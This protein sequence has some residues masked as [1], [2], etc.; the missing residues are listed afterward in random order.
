MLGP[1][2]GAETS[3]PASDTP[4]P[5]SDLAAIFANTVN[6]HKAA[7]F[8][9]IYESTF[10]P[11][12]DR[13]M[14]IL[15]IGVACGGSLELWRQY[16]CPE[17]TVIGIDGNPQCARFDDPARNVHVRIGQQQ[18][19]QFLQSVV[20]EF[21][22][23]DIILDDGAHTP[24]YTRAAFQ[25]LFLHGLADGGVYLVEDLEWCYWPCGANDGSPTFIEFVKSLI[26]VMHLH[27]TVTDTTDAFEVVHPEGLP[28]DHPRRLPE[29]KVPLATTLISSIELHDGI[30]AIHRQQRELPRI[31]MKTSQAYLNAWLRER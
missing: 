22:P 3:W 18:D 21:G 6:I 30:V 23:I 26:D 9:P 28:I 29:V 13:P 1:E 31:L 7:H 2:L 16:F 11:Y 15:E 25:H 10:R 14:K 4:I 24:S 19:K 12:R 17:A 20:D 27:Y 8:V 5:D